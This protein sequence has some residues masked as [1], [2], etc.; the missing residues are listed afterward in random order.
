MKFFFILYVYVQAYSFCADKESL[1]APR[2]VRAGLIQNSIALPTTESFFDQK[3]AIFQKVAPIIEAAGAS[4]VNI[5]CLQ[6]SPG[7]L[8]RFFIYVSSDILHMTH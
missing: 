2:I 8:I 4:G 1:R 5:L 6:V 3:K 7:V